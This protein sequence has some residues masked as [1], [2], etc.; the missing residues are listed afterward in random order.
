VLNSFEGYG[1][2]EMSIL[3]TCS[4]SGHGEG[5]DRHAAR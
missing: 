3:D 1:A 4:E 2:G 5:V